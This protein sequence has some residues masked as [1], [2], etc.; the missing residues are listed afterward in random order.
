MLDRDRA[1]GVVDGV[2]GFAFDL[3]RFGISLVSLSPAKPGGGE[4]RRESESGC[5]CRLASPAAKTS[6]SLL[7]LPIA[8]VLLR[9]LS[10]RHGGRLLRS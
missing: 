7:L 10:S 5:S 4:P 1:V 2:V 8:L 6:M 9:R 3:P